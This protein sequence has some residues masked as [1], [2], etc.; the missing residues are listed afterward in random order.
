MYLTSSLER[1]DCLLELGGA[2]REERLA[3][4]GNG[5][6]YMKGRDNEPCISCT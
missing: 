5:L 4:R 2:S 1:N 6:S 3:N